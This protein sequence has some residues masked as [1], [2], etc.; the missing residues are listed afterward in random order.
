[1]HWNGRASMLC[2]RDHCCFFIA[3]DCGATATRLQST[4]N[5]RPTTQH[6]NAS[7]SIAHLRCSF[8]LLSRA[9][10][11]ICRALH[12]SSNSIYPMNRPSRPTDNTAMM[13]GIRRAYFCGGNGKVRAYSSSTNGYRHIYKI[14]SYTF[15]IPSQLTTTST[16]ML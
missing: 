2:I 16:Q 3:A 13:L 5:S 4:R 12:F 10:S 6:A 7:H 9:M 14:K 11:R 15:A 8:I 1:M